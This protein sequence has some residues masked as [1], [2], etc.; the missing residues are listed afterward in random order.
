MLSDK[1]TLI[2]EAALLAA[3]PIC[4]GITAFVALFT[5]AGI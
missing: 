1:R 2:L 5:L 4:V 3:V